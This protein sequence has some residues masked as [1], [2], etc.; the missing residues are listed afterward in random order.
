MSDTH[1][2]ATGVAALP[3]PTETV[4]RVAE[5]STLEVP[6]R[7]L[8]AAIRCV[9]RNSRRALEGVYLHQ[10]PEGWVRL[11]AT[12]GGKLLLAQLGHRH[13]LPANEALDW[14][15]SGLILA[16]DRL[17]AQLA[18][19]AATDGHGKGAK[20]A[21]TYALGA[22]HAEVSDTRGNASFRVGAIS[23]PWPDYAAI[24]DASAGVFTPEGRED[25][26]PAAFKPGH[27]KS[28]SEI[29]GVLE[30]S[31]L[32]VYT[33]RLKAHRDV[34]VI[35]GP[36]LITFGRVGNVLLYLQPDVGAVTLSPTERTMLAPAIKS[37]VG[38]LRA[39]LTRNERAAKRATGAE[40]Q[41]LQGIADAYRARIERVIGKAGSGDVALPP[42]PK[43]PEPPK[44]A[45]TLADGVDP[46]VEIAEPSHRATPAEPPVAPVPEPAPT[47]PEP[48]PAKAKAKAVKRGVRRR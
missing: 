46:S 21:I 44:P 30:A 34:R 48:E 29:A 24:V 8:A 35:D 43:P 17:K 32:Q 13:Q 15:P 6:W 2:A 16:A 1:V 27:I 39:H 4:E 18:L 38:A 40:K 25:F 26:E 22:P 7:I 5:P 47:T 20:V 3:P 10:T 45:Y 33:H 19:I 28:A 14:L 42:P 36:S 12:D 23:G 37:S 9:G 31:N 41:R 11:A